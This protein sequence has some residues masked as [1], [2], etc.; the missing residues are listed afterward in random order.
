MFCQRFRFAGSDLQSTVNPLDIENKGM[1]RRI[2]GVNFDFVLPC[3]I[4][5]NKVIVHQML[6]IQTHCD[7]FFQ[8]IV[9]PQIVAAL[10][11]TNRGIVEIVSGA[12]YASK[13][14]GA[15]SAMLSIFQPFDGRMI[16]DLNGLTEIVLNFLFETAAA[17]DSLLP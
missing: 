1:I 14:A 7:R 11:E 15:I 5:G 3:P 9:S 8:R 12:V 10:L 16:D 17:C 4:R 2:C 13:T 6:C